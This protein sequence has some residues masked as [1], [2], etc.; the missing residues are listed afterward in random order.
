MKI[1]RFGETRSHWICPMFR[2]IGELPNKQNSADRIIRSALFL[3]SV[4]TLALLAEASPANKTVYM[5]LRSMS[6]SKIECWPGIQS[7]AKDLGLS[8]ST[9]KRAVKDLEKHGYL[10]KETRYRDGLCAI[11]AATQ[12]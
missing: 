2:G 8:R 1:K 10:E 9:V 7:I 4:Y 3:Q 5:Y 11:T 6:V 12:S